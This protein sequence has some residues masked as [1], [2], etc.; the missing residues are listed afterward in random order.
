MQTELQIP[1]VALHQARR[2]RYPQLSYAETFFA[3]APIAAL[4]QSI[5]QSYPPHIPQSTVLPAQSDAATPHVPNCTTL[6]A[7]HYSTGQVTR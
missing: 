6:C 3:R 5:N 7:S 2:R 4:K 1:P